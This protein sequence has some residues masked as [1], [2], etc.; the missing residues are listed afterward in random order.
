MFRTVVLS[1]G[2]SNGIAHAG[3]AAALARE[4]LLD[5][6]SPDRAT[7]SFHCCS[8]G[9]LFGLLMYLR[10][11]ISSAKE[12]GMMRPF[13]DFFKPTL[14]TVRKC[15]VGNLALC[16]TRGKSVIAFLDALI[17]KATGIRRATFAQLHKYNKENGGLWVCVTSLA[18]GHGVVMSHAT[19]PQVQVARAVFASM[20]IPFLFSPVNIGGDLY[21]DGAV[22][23]Q[24]FPLHSAA[25]TLNGGSVV[26][27]GGGG[28]GAEE[29]CAE[30]SVIGLK[31]SSRFAFA[32][33]PT[34]AA[35]LS[36]AQY[37]RRIISIAT[38][39]PE[40]RDLESRF[41]VITINN[42]RSP[43]DFS[44]SRDEEERL[45]ARGRDAVARWLARKLPNGP[46]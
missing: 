24:N 25:A 9:A 42:N 30:R 34:N 31:L 27:G 36:F 7:S 21:V 3:A 40:M 35:C 10:V 38:T 44:P 14:S 37:F 33:T 43:V 6:T 4:N 15:D 20:L 16:G 5:W 19:H 11:D 26:G 17:Q 1:G 2:G 28:G 13:L 45:L 8:V 22:S 32:R 12:L 41:A 18:T 23:G 39:R 46:Q 29:N